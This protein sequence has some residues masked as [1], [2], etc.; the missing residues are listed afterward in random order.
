MSTTII[1]TEASWEFLL[2]LAEGRKMMRVEERGKG[3]HRNA[4]AGKLAGFGL[5]VTPRTDQHG[6]NGDVVV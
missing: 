6:R 1:L 4:I 2:K 3:S 5:G